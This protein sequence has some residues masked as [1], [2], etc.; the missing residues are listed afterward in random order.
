M[1]LT[2]YI[3]DPRQRPWVFV[4]SIAGALAI[5]GGAVGVVM[6][7]QK[8]DTEQRLVASFKKSVARIPYSDCVTIRT[9]RGMSEADARKACRPMLTQ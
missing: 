3:P 2:D 6:H 8:P 4:F 1:K 5:V 9:T 7:Q